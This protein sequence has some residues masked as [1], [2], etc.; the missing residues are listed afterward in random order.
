MAGQ[1]HPTQP[2]QLAGILNGRTTYLYHAAD[3]TGEASSLP[4]TIRAATPELGLCATSSQGWN[5]ALAGPT[6][7]RDL[8]TYRPTRVLSPGYSSVEPSDRVTT[9]MGT[10]SASSSS[11]RS[12]GLGIRVVTMSSLRSI[13]VSVGSAVRTNVP[14]APVSLALYMSSHLV[15]ATQD[16]VWV[17][18]GRLHLRFMGWMR[19]QDR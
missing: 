17:P 13:T 7:A 5:K 14:R 15:S 19:I 3:R 16:L 18:A 2:H 11:R 12:V 10:P 1:H 9:R 8:C 6:Y 4:P